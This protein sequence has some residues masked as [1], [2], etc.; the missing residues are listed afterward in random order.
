MGMGMAPDATSPRALPSAH[1]Q[2]HPVLKG[3]ELVLLVHLGVLH[4]LILTAHALD[5]LQQRITLTLEHLQALQHV[6]VA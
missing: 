5:Q 2:H 3:L 1:P 4:S 6:T